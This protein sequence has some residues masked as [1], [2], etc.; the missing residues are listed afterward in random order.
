MAVSHL[1]R[2]CADDTYEL[3]SFCVCF[4]LFFSP[5]FFSLSSRKELSCEELH[6]AFTSISQFNSH[7]SFSHRYSRKALLSQLNFQTVSQEHQIPQELGKKATKYGYPPE[8][9]LAATL[10]SGAG[11]YQTH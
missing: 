1:E 2:K 3:S 9:S 5:Q 4:W 11:P 6:T 8:L 10:Q 7:A